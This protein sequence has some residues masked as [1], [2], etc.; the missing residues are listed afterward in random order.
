MKGLEWRIWLW[1]SGR[2]KTC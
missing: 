1:T 2:S